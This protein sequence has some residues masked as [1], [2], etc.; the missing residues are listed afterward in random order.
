MKKTVTAFLSV[1]C[2]G[3]FCSI[4]FTGCNIDTTDPEHTH[5]YA[6]EWSFDNTY[7]WHACTGGNCSEISDKAQHAFENDICTVCGYEQSAP[8]PLPTPSE[9]EVTEEQ[10]N[11]ALSFSGV[12]SLTVVFESNENEMGQSIGSTTYFDGNKTKIVSSG[13]GM[14]VEEYDMFAYL[15][16]NDEQ[17][18]TNWYRTKIEQTDEMYSTLTTFNSWKAEFANFDFSNFS[19]ADGYYSG[20]CVFDEGTVDEYIG[21]VKLE[22]K[23]GKLV[24]LDVKY[25]IESFNVVYN[26]TFSG[27]NE[28]TITLPVNYNDIN[29]NSQ[30]PDTSSV[31]ASYFDLPNVTITETMTYVKNGKKENSTLKTVWKTDKNA[32]ICYQDYLSVDGDVLTTNVIYF[33][34]TN[35]YFNGNQAAEG[36][37]WYHYRYE[38]LFVEL[39]NLESSFEKSTSNSTTVL[40]S[41]DTITLYGVTAYTNV[42]IMVENGRI[43]TIVYTKANAVM[44][45]N[46][47][48]SYSGTYTFTFTNYGTTEVD[49]AVSNPSEPPSAHTHSSMFVDSRSASCTENGNIEYWYCSV[50]NKYFFDENCTTE[51][52]LG[53]TVVVAQHCLIF[54]DAKNKTCAD[55]GNIAHYHCSKC[56]KNFSDEKATTEVDDVTVEACHEYG[57]WI[58]GRSATCS[59]EGERGHYECSDCGKYFDCYYGEIGDIVVPTE[60]HDFVNGYCENCYEEEFSE[61]V[62]FTLLDDDTYSVSEG[63]FDGAELIIPNIHNSKKVTAVGSEGFKNC[64]L[65]SSVAIGKNVQ[66]I[67][68]SAFYGCGSLTNVTI[69]NNVTSIGDNAFYNCDLLDTVTIGENVRYIGYEAFASCKKLNNIIYR[70]ID[71]DDMTRFDRVFQYG[72][73]ADN[74]I[75][76]TI[77]AKVEK[78]PSYLFDDANVVS[79]IFENDS[80]CSSIGKAAFSFSNDITSVS[81]YYNNDIDKWVEIEGL[82]SLMNGISSERKLYINNQL[83]TSVN[84]NKASKI[85]NSAFRNCT[86]LQSITVGDGVTSIGGDAF[87]GCTSLKTVTLGKNIKAI[88]SDAFRD[89]SYLQKVN[90]SGDINGW[91]EIE[92]IDECSNP[93][94]NAENLYIKDALVVSAEI[95]TATKIKPY[96]FYGC[97]SL[98]SITIGE[99]ITSIGKRAFYVKHNSLK[100]VYYGGDINSWVQ[101]KFDSYDANP[102]FEAENLYIGNA[103]LNCAD[104][105]K[106]TAI[107]DYAFYGCW[108][109]E[110]IIIGD[111]VTFIGKDAFTNCGKLNLNILNNVYYLGNENNKYLVCYRAVEDSMDCYT[112]SEHTKFIH[113]GAFEHC[114]SLISITI[115]DSV[116]SIG[117]RAFAGC[118][119]LKNIHIG[120]KV[121]SI[122]NEAFAVCKTITTVDIPDSVVFIGSKAFRHCTSLE[123]IQM[124]SGVATI[125]DYAFCG[126][127]A[128][129]YAH[130]PNNVTSVGKGVYQDCTSL[131]SVTMDNVVSIG[132]GAFYDCTKLKN[133][134]IGSGLQLIGSSAFG[135]CTALESI[136]LPSSVIS[137]N[138][139]AFDRCKVLSIYCLASSQSNNWAYN[140]NN[141]GCPVYWYSEGTP[142]G[143]GSFWHYSA[144]GK[145]II[146]W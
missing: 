93:L 4:V 85:S 124:G 14:F 137:I 37:D 127:T 117:D 17:N 25:Q 130:V 66:S 7:H 90:Y 101:I 8:T 29:A 34:G 112:I 75:T 105:D 91:V 121:V 67:G 53:S 100:S 138:Q 52:T 2:V 3:L 113:S 84:V 64:S 111:C 50:C 139:F 59:E 13:M 30:T 26:Y 22:F 61:G 9:N 143:I 99:N 89:C 142:T 19:Y 88:G 40:Y 132:D 73:G 43:T 98:N 122:G 125:G 60:R 56:Q 62:L 48:E 102:L 107:N 97:A 123:S 11:A 87:Y 1:L 108:S 28:T 119:S 69:P 78:V 106:A 63:S 118:F 33:D 76:L 140:W 131:E 38:G 133:I 103:L 15:F 71:C 86:S 129:K 47:D 32:W 109:L 58:N 114:S 57:V 46:S 82:S 83:L 128:L 72:V 31:W 21:D 44:D 16:Y 80:K 45:G 141:W 134:T 95:D 10:F 35:G 74:G 116:V 20:E 104:I 126:C 146:V 51:I 6:T 70:A 27:Y 135:N 136:I 94:Y 41:A 36:V 54:V 77:G 144:D 12:T 79:V 42:Q 96:A 55:N 39:E 49:Y 68:N 81:I 120:A 115:P 92:F 23:D 110:N 24:Y 5:T 145:T 18:T 65:L